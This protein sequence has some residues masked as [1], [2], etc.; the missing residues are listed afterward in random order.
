LDLTG[1]PH[2]LDPAMEMSLYRI[3][4]EALTN[5]RKHAPMARAHVTLRYLAP[6]VEV[7][8]VNG[9]RVPSAK[10][11]SLPGFGRGLI[12]IRERAALFDGEASAGPTVEGGFRASARLPLQLVPA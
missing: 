10:T 4:Q 8:V 2:L 12:G 5:V 7:E 6:Q 9:P 1:D 11:D 3:V